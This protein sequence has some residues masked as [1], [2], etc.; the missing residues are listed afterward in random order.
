MNKRYV[1]GNWKMHGSL[2]MVDA[3][4]RALAYAPSPDVVAA[5]APPHP[6][7]GAC[8]DLPHGCGLAGQDCSA[9]DN[10]AHT[11]EVSASMLFEWGCGW[12][13]VGHSERRTDLAESD[14]LI[15]AKLATAR[16][17]GLIPVLCVGES[18]AMRDAGR[19]ETVVREQLRAVLS[20]QSPTS[21]LVAYEPIWAIGTGVTASPEQADAMHA[22][23]RDELATLMTD[24]ASVPLLYGGS[25]NPDNAR[26]LF[27]C[28]H[29]DGALVGGA[30]LDAT[31]F[32]KIVEAAQA[33]LEK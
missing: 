19:A 21:L 13:I 31:S 2:A 18:L 32:S 26:G 4:S 20:D 14:Q 33:S 7:L 25:V 24:G 11:G 9:H 29:V 6:Y 10:G 8:S 12:V 3:F 1:I 16:S 30:S 27:D 22:V 15:A 28:P 17:A 5:I 23:I